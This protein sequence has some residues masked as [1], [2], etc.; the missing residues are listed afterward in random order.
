MATETTSQQES[1]P[2]EGKKEEGKE[3]AP[4][5]GSASTTAAGEARGA[6]GGSGGEGT[7]VLPDHLPVPSMF[8]S[9]SGPA[10]GGVGGG[11]GG[12]ETRPDHLPFPPMFR[13]FSSGST[14]ASGG[15]GDGSGVARV[16]SDFT[17]ILHGL[18]QYKMM[19]AMR[20]GAAAMQATSQSQSGSGSGSGSASGSGS[21]LKTPL[22]PMMTP[23]FGLSPP[24]SEVVRQPSTV[25]NSFDE[26]ITRTPSYPIADM[27]GQAGFKDLLS[28]GVW[29]NFSSPP[30]SRVQSGEEG[31]KGLKRSKEGE[32]EGEGKGEAK[33][34]G[35]KK[36]GGKAEDAVE[37]G[38]SK[39]GKGR[40]SKSKEG[41]KGATSIR[42]K[43]VNAN[44]ERKGQ[45]PVRSEVGSS[46]CLVKT[47]K[48]KGEKKGE[49][50]TAAKGEGP[51][52]VGL[53][54]VAEQKI[55][56]KLD[57]MANSADTQVAV[58]L[59][60]TLTAEQVM[61]RRAKRIQAAVEE[62]EKVVA[63]NPFDIT[64]TRGVQPMLVLVGDAIS[65]FLIGSLK[66]KLNTKCR[67]DSKHAL[68]AMQKKIMAKFG[69]SVKAALTESASEQRWKR[70]MRAA[71]DK[72]PN[73]LSTESYKTRQER[74]F[75]LHVN[76]FY[77][78]DVNTILPDEVVVRREVIEGLR[79]H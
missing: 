17:A 70:W 53:Q 66:G 29:P 20:A 52:K 63:V 1:Q 67:L 19:L 8:R 56:K 64:N 54:K 73:L 28:S 71:T 74:H 34:G 2:N 4:K 35:K 36:K 11:G 16:P 22:M 26:G 6:G 21:G 10:N 41:K 9:A 12:E 65:D 76:D 32:E 38:I 48:E 57:S 51:Q 44:S 75:W 27:Q 33:R 39:N 78:I 77:S 68:Y 30:L 7:R 25:L 13:S 3:E 45:T 55:K 24:F 50:E 18:L 79:M 23:P 58:K 47:E 59:D 61:E 37:V 31:G 42:R 49:G 46:P 40:I 60:S 14:P 43:P 5:I 62:V 69:D 15:E 72:L